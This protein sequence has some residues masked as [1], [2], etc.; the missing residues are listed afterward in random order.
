MSAI[1]D[2]SKGDTVDLYF[3]SVN[4]SG[5]PTTL[6]GTPAVSVYKNNST[7]QSTSGVTLTADFDGVTGLNQVRITTNSDGTFYDVGG[8]FSVIVTTGTVGGSSVVGYVVGS[9]SIEA[10]KGIADSLLKR[11]LSALAG[12]AARSLLNAI[13]FL[14]NKWTLSG[15][16]LTVYKEDDTTSAWTATTTNSASADPITGSDPS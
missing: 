3:T 10:R 15:T 8:S 14:R 5:V 2:F 16:T 9:F 13:R 12:E 4:A 7:T 11:D 6:S 1:G